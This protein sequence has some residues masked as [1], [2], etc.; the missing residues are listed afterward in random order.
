MLDQNGRETNSDLRKWVQKG[1]FETQGAEL[2]QLEE[3]NIELFM[4]HFEERKETRKHKDI[5]TLR[6][7]FLSQRRRVGEHVQGS[8]K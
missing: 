7:T 5:E 2:R 1:L 4:H 3:S 8:S 6:L